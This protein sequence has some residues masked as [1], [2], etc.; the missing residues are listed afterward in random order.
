[1]GGGGDPFAGRKFT[2]ANLQLV[3]LALLAEKPAH[4]Y[5]LIRILEERSNGFY[6][7]SPGV[8]YPALTYLEEIGHAQVEQEGNRKLYKITEAGRQHL[9]AHRSEAETML[10][11]LSRIGSRMEHMREAFEGWHDLDA[12]SSHEMHRARHDLKRAMMRT[13]GCSPE[14]TRRI[15]EILDHATSEILH[16]TKKETRAQ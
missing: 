14:E 5:E 9:E 11:V 12:R 16:V 3:L 4:G 1:M 13:H 6:T 15:I 7:P 2:S 10:E 8:I